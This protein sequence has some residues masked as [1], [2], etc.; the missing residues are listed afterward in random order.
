MTQK[1]DFTKFDLEAYVNEFAERD[2]RKSRDG[3]AWYKCCFHDEKTASLHVSDKQAYY[4]HG[5]GAGGGVFDFVKRVNNT[6]T[7]EALNIILERS[8]QESVVVYEDRQPELFYVPSE[9]IDSYSYNGGFILK[10]RMPD[11]KF[12]WTHFEDGEWW[13][14]T[15]GKDIELYAPRGIEG[16]VILAE[17]EK[18]ANTLC[19]MGY[20]GISTPH[21]THKWKDEYTQQ[22][23]QASMVVI[24]N[25]NDYLGTA[26]AELAEHY[27]VE[28]GLKVKRISPVEIEPSEEKGYDITDVVEI[29][30]EEETKIRLDDLI[31]S[32]R[33]S[34]EV[35]HVEV[36][37]ESGV[38]VDYDEFMIRAVQETINNG[39]ISEL[40]DIEM[41]KLAKKYN[42]GIRSIQSRIKER[43]AAEKPRQALD[44]KHD[45]V[46]VE[47]I[48]LEID[49]KGSGYVVQE[50]SG[51]I[52][53][54]ENGYQIIGH[55]LAFVG[56]V[57]DAEAD[58]D[59]NVKVALAY[60]TP[61]NLNKYHLL[62][63]PKKSLAT[64][65][66]IIKNLTGYNINVTQANA[67]EVVKYLQDLQDY[68]KENTVMLSS[69]SR[70][71]WFKDYL[72]PYEQDKVGIVFDATVAQPI[73]NK[74]L[75]K[76]GDREKSLQLIK[77]V[78][79]YSESNAV[80]LG[81]S[82]ASLVLSYLNDG[83]NQSFAL[84][85]WNESGYGKSVVAQAISSIF[86]YPFK[87]GGW[88]TKANST[89]NTDIYHNS[90]M[91]HLPT[92]IDDPAR[93]RGYNSEQKRD[94]IYSVTSGQGRGRMNRDGEIPRD[95]KEWCNVVIMTNET[96]FVDDSIPD[97]GAKAR[98]IEVAFS[99]P[100]KRKTVEKWLDIMRH[101][102]GHFAVDIANHIRET[103]KSILQE[104]IV[105]Y[106]RYFDKENVEGKRSLNAA[107]IAL[108]LEVID[109]ALG[110]GAP[111]IRKWLAKEIRGSGT[112]SDG[113]R[114][115]NK[116]MSI[117]Q[118]YDS[119]FR[120]TFD[121]NGMFIGAFGEGTDGRK[122]VFLPI[123]TLNKFSSE[124]DFRVES[125]LSW[126]HA[127]EKMVPIYNEDGVPQM[128]TI[129]NHQS[130]VSVYQLY[131]NWRGSSIGNMPNTSPFYIDNK[132]E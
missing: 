102:H 100:L 9:V 106:T 55:F 39:M 94:Y 95:V 80:M 11:K 109:D 88:W 116:L 43:V 14:G 38:G 96:V 108:G 52:W 91:G 115:Y 114:A 62:I 130:K 50:D 21:G 15:G 99:K 48:G 120:D 85:V 54:E 127:N 69:L 119:V 72:M 93:N 129:T 44:F 73:A 42:M 84:N 126:S 124:M 51:A 82:V 53:N 4:C 7:K 66:D 40:S 20:T 92:F 59:T 70:F 71:G 123:T 64:T 83:G 103:G 107:Y 35:A 117:V 77:E 58:Q 37:W 125:L 63:I 24:L 18:D 41:R 45:V 6:T 89:L 105:Q 110:L 86:G 101:N 57:I 65:Q 16:T 111:D 128:V 5:C 31:E 121:R 60:N 67:L 1:I 32:T 3:D 23:K 49:I 56:V 76:V 68:F 46:K 122:V 22:L 131:Y 118:T 26:G 29:I 90:L 112:L 87:D 61:Q 10:Y 79:Q 13:V 132:E 81:A 104:R 74:L 12:T 78:A 98:C 17:G 33:Y 19:L 113:A 36:V 30:G 2:S 47:E 97:G 75:E 25:D 28:A 8:G 27:L 34:K